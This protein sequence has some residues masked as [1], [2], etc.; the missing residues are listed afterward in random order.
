MLVY[1]PGAA[2]EW[3]DGDAIPAQR[4]EPRLGGSGRRARR[5]FCGNVG[6][7]GVHSASSDALTRYV[8]SA[9][10]HSASWTALPA[11][12]HVRDHLY[13]AVSYGQLLLLGGHDGISGA[14]TTTVSAIDV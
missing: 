10:G 8:P 9:A 5:H 1:R 3:T 13:A 12:P 7:H 6:G 2:R 4:F 14:G 11:A